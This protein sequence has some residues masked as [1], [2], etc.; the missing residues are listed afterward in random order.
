MSKSEEIKAALQKLSAEKSGLLR[1]VITEIVMLVIMLVLLFTVDIKA[2]YAA[3]AVTLIYNFLILHP[4]KKRYLANINRAECLLGVGANLQDCEYSLK[5]G[6]PKDMLEKACLVTPRTWPAE[7]VC[8]HRLKGKYAG[9]Q[10]QISEC[11]FA[12]KYGAANG[13]VAFVSG[14][15]IR[16]ELTEDARQ[17]LCCMR[18]DVDYVSDGLPELECYGLSRCDFGS[19]KANETNLAYSATGEIPEWLEKRFLKLSSTAPALLSLQGKE[20]VI[21]LVSRF[22]APRHK[23]SDVLTEETLS[24]NRLPETAAA[25]DIIKI[26]QHKAAL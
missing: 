17:M 5:D 12:L 4:A 3:G 2:V 23:V 1:L 15:C 20:L 24:F 16:A 6:L 7:A 11:S 22:Y 8:R 9:A 10:V 18:R 13:A 19:A 14:S 26:I 21:L 25:L